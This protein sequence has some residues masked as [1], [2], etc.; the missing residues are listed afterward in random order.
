[1]G[2]TNLVYMD[3]RKRKKNMKRAEIIAALSDKLRLCVKRQ[4]PPSHL[5]ATKQANDLY[6]PENRQAVFLS[7]KMSKKVTPQTGDREIY[8]ICISFLFFYFCGH[9]KLLKPGDGGNQSVMRVSE[10]VEQR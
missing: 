7:C 3:S 9:A 8:S 2:K 10:S 6:M 1:M 5:Q 4:V